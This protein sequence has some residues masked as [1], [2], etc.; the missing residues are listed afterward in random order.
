M[1]TSPLPSDP[2]DLAIAAGEAA[3]EVLPAATPL[4]AGGAQPGTEHVVSSFAGAAVAAVAGG[5]IAVLVGDELV[6][7]LEASPLGGLDLAAAVQPALDAVAAVL[8][9]SAQAATQVELTLVVADLG[10]PFTVVP[11]IGSG[12]AAA[13]LLPDALLA[14]GAAAGGTSAGAA[15][16]ASGAAT[17]EAASVRDLG[18]TALGGISGSGSGSGSGVIPLV[19]R[20]IE[21]LHGVDM[22]VTVE[23]GRTR[24]A[25]RDLLAL[26]PGAV[27]ELDRAA[28]SP[29]DLLVNGRL[30]ARGEV[31][32]VD[33]DFGLRVTEI[34]DD[35]A[36]S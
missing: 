13:L 23:L 25:V 5:R 6:A 27:L 10:G 29:A 4:V 20:G 11:L 35:Q 31:V 8:G 15:P 14:P 24:M 22:E 16:V 30:I 19:H 17:G 12:I 21:M 36:A 26:A 2:N 3:A 9:A 34:L 1:T 28:G 7:A 18:A 32:V 33:E